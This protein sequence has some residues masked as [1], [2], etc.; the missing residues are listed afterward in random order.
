MQQFFSFD[1]SHYLSISL[2]FN[3]TWICL[4][5]S[6]CFS[7]TLNGRPLAYFY[8]TQGAEFLPIVGPLVLDWSFHSS[9]IISCSSNPDQSSHLHDPFLHL[10]VRVMILQL[11]A[12]NQPAAICSSRTN[13]QIGSGVSVSGGIKD[14][15]NSNNYYFCHTLF[16]YFIEY[17]EDKFSRGKVE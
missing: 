1:L 12:I 7:G 8:P 15:L 14:A 16:M 5:F 9:S 11:C 13:I 2:L 17:N 10:Y 6:D 3:F 4:V